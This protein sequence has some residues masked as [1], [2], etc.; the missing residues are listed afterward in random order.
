[1]KGNKL[2]NGYLWLQRI[3]VL[4]NSA[5]SKG[6]VDKLAHLVSL[7]DVQVLFSFL[8]LILD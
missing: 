4:Q 2:S 7:Q 5:E 6:F 8:K 1:M 3:E